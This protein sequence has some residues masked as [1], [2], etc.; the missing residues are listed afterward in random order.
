M[1]AILLCK[2]CQIVT[3]WSEACRKRHWEEKHRN[4]CPGLENAPD[5]NVPCLEAPRAD[6]DD[7]Q[8]AA[9]KKNDTESEEDNQT[10]DP[11][12]DMEEEIKSMQR[13]IALLHG[14]VNSL[15]PGPRQSARIASTTRRRPRSAK[16]TETSAG[17]TTGKKIHRFPERKL[18]PG[19]EYPCK[20]CERMLKT[21]HILACT[22]MGQEYATTILGRSRRARPT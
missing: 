14:R 8:K 21:Q 3:N 1:D 13:E 10:G 9:S 17:K 11:N 18:K 2:E 20:N 6:N 5:P 15:T 4:W 16:S 22:T 12:H 7:A 19:E